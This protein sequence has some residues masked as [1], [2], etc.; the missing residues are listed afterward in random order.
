MWPSS[1][2]SGAKRSGAEPSRVEWSGV[3]RRETNEDRGASPSGKVSVPRRESERDAR[4][5]R[6][7]KETRTGRNGAESKLPYD[8][9]AEGQRPR[10]WHN[11][12]VVRAARFG[13]H[14]ASQWCAKSRG[15]CNDGDKERERERENI[16]LQVCI[17]RLLRERRLKRGPGKEERE[18]ES[19]CIINIRP[20]ASRDEIKGGRDR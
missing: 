14:C 13:D 3:A 20:A 6:R 16:F 8:D 17:A 12:Q 5:R 10:R 19:T 15:V 2:R 1:E 18:K 4:E 9:N 7:E 11:L